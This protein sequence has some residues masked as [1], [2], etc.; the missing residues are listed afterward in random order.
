[1]RQHY[2]STKYSSRVDAKHD[3]VLENPKRILI[4]GRIAFLRTRESEYFKKLLII[5]YEKENQ[6][7][8][9]F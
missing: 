3:M 2:F 4:G 8:C 5:A 1:M 9:S 6:F 7:F